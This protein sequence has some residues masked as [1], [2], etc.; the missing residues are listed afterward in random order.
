MDTRRLVCN[1]IDYIIVPEVCRPLVSRAQS[2]SGTTLSSDHKLV[3]GY[4]H[5]DRSLDV[6]L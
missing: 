1:M 3:I 4:L 6:H 5:L 2:Y